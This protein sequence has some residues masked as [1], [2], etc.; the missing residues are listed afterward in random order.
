MK[1]KVKAQARR[2]KEPWGAEDP[3]GGGLRKLGRAVYSMRCAIQLPGSGLCGLQLGAQAAAE[4]GRLVGET[5]VVG[6]AWGGAAARWEEQRRPP[7]PSSFWKQ[8]FFL[9]VGAE[10]TDGPIQAEPPCLVI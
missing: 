10:P 1:V 6:G 8:W 4:V 2:G 9:D 5:G 3:R 7:F